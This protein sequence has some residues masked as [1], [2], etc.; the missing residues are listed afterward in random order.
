MYNGTIQSNSQNCTIYWNYIHIKVLAM[1]I[2]K[3]TQ[4][5]SIVRQIPMCLYHIKRLIFTENKVLCKKNITLKNNIHNKY[6]PKMNIKVLEIKTDATHQP[7]QG[8]AGN[9]Y[10]SCI[11]SELGS[12]IFKSSIESKHYAKKFLIFL[13]TWNFIR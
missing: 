9:F 3:Q 6:T 5:T 12:P 10:T 2:I 4:H 8:P 1:Y 13:I 7:K 11:W